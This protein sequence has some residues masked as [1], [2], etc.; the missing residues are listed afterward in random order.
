M[1]LQHQ[2]DIQRKHA[3]L[4]MQRQADKKKTEENI[5]SQL[6]F[7]FFHFSDFF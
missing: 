6:F 2:K 3:I 4:K 5:I 7:G 1:L